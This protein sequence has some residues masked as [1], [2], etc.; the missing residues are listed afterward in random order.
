MC[1]FDERMHP[2]CKRGVRKPGV[3]F[4]FLEDAPVAVIH[5]PSLTGQDSCVQRAFF[6]RRAAGILLTLARKG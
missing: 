3:G 2:L 5:G 1:G 6:A 4:Q